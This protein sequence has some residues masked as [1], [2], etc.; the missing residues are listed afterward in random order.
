MSSGT[1]YV[2]SKLSSRVIVV[3]AE[4]KKGE[5]RTVDTTEIKVRSRRDQ[6]SINVVQINSISLYDCGSHH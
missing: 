2:R 6:R 3:V 5:R 1:L 4:S